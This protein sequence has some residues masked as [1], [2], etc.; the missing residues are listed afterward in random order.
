MEPGSRIDPQA[1]ALGKAKGYADRVTNG[2][3]VELS[4]SA[5]S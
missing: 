1:K 5:A 4:G 2:Q 3:K